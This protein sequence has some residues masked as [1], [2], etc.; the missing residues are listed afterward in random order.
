M[1]RT[2][3]LA[4]FATLFLCVVASAVQ[5]RRPEATRENPRSQ[6]QESPQQMKQL[7]HRVFEDLFNNG[8]YGAIS[9]IY[10]GNCVVHDSGKTVPL[11]HSVAEGKNFRSAAPDVRMTPGGMSVQGNIVT[12]SWT[13]RGSHTGRANGLM[14]PTGKH[15]QVTGTSRFR[16]ENGKIVEVWNDWDRN[17]LF[18]QIGVSPTAAYLYDKAEDVMLALER[19]FPLGPS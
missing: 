5:K 17:G 9:E 2:A 13:G 16:I 7:V 11:E 8:R 6:A 15:F 14:K 12:V 18:R 3:I 1:R 10:A 19:I 4:L